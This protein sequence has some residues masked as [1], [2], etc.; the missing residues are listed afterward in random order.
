MSERAGEV[1]A[2]PTLQDAERLLAR[3]DVDGA[4]RLAIDHLRKHRDEPRGLALLGRIA[5]Q[6]G[7]LLQSERFLRRAIAL[8]VG[9]FDTLF[10]LADNLRQQER[11][12]EADEAF[13]ALAE[14]FDDPRL[15]ATRAT[16]VERLGNADEAAALHRAAVAADPG[17]S[18]F[19]IPYGHSLRFAGDTEGAVA[20]YRDVLARDPERGEAWWALADIKARVLTDEDV[21]AMKAALERAIDIRNIVPLHMALGRA[22]HDRGEHETAFGHY[23]TGNRLRA[24][25]LAYDPATLTRDIDRLIALADSERLAPAVEREGPTP[26]FLVSQPRSGS[27][28]LEQILGRHPAIEAVGELPYTLALLRSALEMRMTRGPIDS[29]R[30][31]EAMNAGE[32]SALGEE[33]LRR[34]GAHRRTDKPFFIDKM[35]TNWPD[36]LFIRAI[37]PQAR[38]IE[39]R[40]G[41]MDCC[42][43]NYTHHFASTHP[44]SFDLVHQAMNYRDYARFTDHVAAT[45]PRF[46]TRV[47]YEALVDSPEPVVRR[48]LEELGL[49]WADG[50]LDPRRSDRSVRTPSAEQVR[51]PINR[52]G[53]GAWRPY[54]KWLGPLRDALGP[55]ADA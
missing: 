40:R 26:I 48:V 24:E 9:D 55:L 37:L 27:T 36:L 43:S 7:A 52:S 19:R 47:R 12:V 51:R 25:E 3:G 46:M 10:A 5:I 18:R 45:S 41:A 17:E 44:A 21:A 32:R 42:F 22:Y 15:V 54:A 28:L 13:A 49:D 38:F 39:I 29:P 33:Y 34:A 2:F 6:S 31:V 20:A 30:L 14:R 11:L 23:S 1:S 50:L 53:I 35:P 4:S 8:G 16:I